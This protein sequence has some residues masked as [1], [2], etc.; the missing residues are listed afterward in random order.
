MKSKRR[1]I[2]VL[3]SV[4]ILFAVA[5]LNNLTA[6][7][8]EEVVTGT[9]IK[10]EEGIIIEAEDADY[11]VQGKDFGN[12]VGKVVEATGVVT[13]TADGYVIEVTKVEELE[14]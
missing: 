10:T 3:L 4:F 13:E 6:A 1:L 11:L 2:S 5:S 9:V 8:Q 12:M 14:E 7:E